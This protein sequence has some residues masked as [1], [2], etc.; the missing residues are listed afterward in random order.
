[1]SATTLTGPAAEVRTRRPS[2]LAAELQRMTARRFVRLLVIIGAL[3]YLV[4]LVVATTQFSKPT[5]AILD[6]ARAKQAQV[7]AESEA[8]RQQCVANP[9][10]PLPPGVT[11]VDEICGGPNTAD[12][13]PLDQFIGKSPF[14]LA[15]DYTTGA[16]GVAAGTAAVMFLI[17]ATYVGAE[18]STKTMTALLFWEPRRLKV[19]GTKAFVVAVTAAVLAV[20][21]QLVWS[22]AARFL[23][24]TRGETDVPDG[25]LSEALGVQ[26]RGVLLVVLVALL[27]FGL[28]NLIRN[29]G[30][31]L[32]VAFVWFAVLENLVRAVRPAWQRW[33]VSD[34]VGAL[35]SPGGTRFGYPGTAVDAN[36]NVQNF[37]EV[38]LSNL[39]GGLVLGVVTAAVLVVGTVLFRRRDLQ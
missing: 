8:A 13:I 12:S 26:A 25:W 22:G 10:S 11:S 3:G 27:G 5:Q 32:G 15:K 20:L 35:V 38:H 34:N 6:D 33:L 21:A 16:V 31:A 28:A 23:A 7:L 19:V 24:T 39:H 9:P 29:T 37:V 14:R 4:A 1:M 2:L 30:A 36:G 17:G 18:W